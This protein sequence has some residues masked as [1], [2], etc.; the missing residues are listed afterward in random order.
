MRKQGVERTLDLLV[1]RRPCGSLSPF[2]RV[3]LMR[4]VE[5]SDSSLLVVFGDAISPE[6]NRRVIELFH[7]LQQNPDPRISNLHPAYATLLIDF[8][9]L[10]LPLEELRARVTELAEAETTDSSSGART[11]VKIPVCYGGELGPDLGD[12]AVHCGM[13]PEEVIERHSGTV[14]TVYFI[15]FSPGFPYMGML[16]ESLAT[17]RLKTPRTSVPAGSVGIGGSQ[18]GLYPM[19]WSGGWRL[20]G[21]TPLRMFDPAAN[22]PSRLQ[23]GDLVKFDPITREAFDAM[24]AGGKG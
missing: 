23:P 16:P 1:W 9:P 8:D 3:L 10:R 2:G 13:S 24:V 5:A 19:Q 7:K 21:R 18:T 6:L 14:Y 17:P 12:V 22:P 15:G 4:L 20:L 11:P